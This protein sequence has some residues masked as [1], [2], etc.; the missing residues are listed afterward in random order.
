MSNRI[1]H[2]KKKVV[3]VFIEYT[4]LIWVIIFVTNI[5]VYYTFSF[6]IRASTDN[7]SSPSV[8]LEPD[9]PPVYPTIE[10]TIEFIPTPSP[11]PA[12]PVVQLSFSMPGIGTYGGNLLPLHPIRDVIVYLYKPDANTVDKRVKPLHT[13]KTQASYDDNPY[14][15]TYT[16]FIN[17]YVDLGKEVTT[18]TNY[19]IVLRTPQALLQLIKE[20][21]SNSP[22]GEIFKTPSTDIFLTLPYQT[23]INGDIFPPASPDNIM[24]ISDYNMLVNCFSNKANSGLCLNPNM[25]DLDDNGVIDGID[26]NLMLLNFRLLKGR[27][28]PVPSL[29]L[30]NPIIINPVT[31]HP[32][33]PIQKTKLTPAITPVKTGFPG[34]MTIISAIIVLLSAAAFIAFKLH[35]LDKFLHKASKE[36]PAPQTAIE[37][38]QESANNPASDIPASIGSQTTAEQNSNPEIPQIA[39]ADSPIISASAQSIPNVLAPVAAESLS[40]PMSNDMMEKSGF[41]KKATVDM[42][43]NGTWVTLADDDGITRGFYQG[44]DIVDGFVKVKGLM[45][46]DEQNKPYLFIT[47]ITAE[48]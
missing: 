46:N 26:Y 30:P 43:K 18:E 35:L 22:G 28:Y 44:T 48:E 19:Q 4:I 15:T 41:L 21:G 8:A 25:A 9:M 29:S 2:P 42:E 16:Y 1:H 27:G 12:G 11:L 34:I 14:S 24:D 7:S 32:V 38:E 39:S 47:E 3:Q 6:F 31:S 13:I 23:M 33:S 37:S 45:K 20:S 5:V 36:N 10:P 17:P 40:Q